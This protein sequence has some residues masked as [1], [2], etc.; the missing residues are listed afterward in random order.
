MKG[1]ICARED[2]ETLLLKIFQSPLE[3]SPRIEAVA[4]GKLKVNAPAEFVMPQS[5]FIAVVEVAMVRA[6]VWAEPYVCNIERTPV[7]VKDSTPAA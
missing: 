6:P 1:K 2:E 7:F 5:L 4:V 3:R